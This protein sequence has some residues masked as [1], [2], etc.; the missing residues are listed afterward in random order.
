MLIGHH[1]YGIAAICVS[2]IPPSLTS[3][4]GR[5]YEFGVEHRPIP[6]NYSHSEVHTYHNGDR[7]DDLK[8]DPPKQI[9]KKFR[10]IL[11]QR[12]EILNIEADP[13]RDQPHR[14]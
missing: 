1:G 10:E 14:C 11:R 4:D 5:V 8:K 6:T 3:E 7:L 9:R 13:E 2:D 12:L